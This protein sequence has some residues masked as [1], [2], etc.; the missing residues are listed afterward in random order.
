MRDREGEEGHNPPSFI[1]TI[2][3]NITHQG[4]IAAM[5]GTRLQG[6]PFASAANNPQNTR[7]MDKKKNES[8]GLRKLLEDQVADIYY[9]EKN[10]FPALK[11]MAKAAETAS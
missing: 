2:G 3:V 11:Q 8:T 5:R 6:V 1:R 7:I 9:V 10:L 4:P